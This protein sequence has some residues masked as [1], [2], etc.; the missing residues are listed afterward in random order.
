LNK[1]KT[2]KKEAK[3]RKDKNLIDPYTGEVEDP[4]EDAY[5][6][7]E[8]VPVDSGEREWE[9]FLL[10]E[11]TPLDKIAG[12]AEA[13]A[14]NERTNRY[15]DDENIEEVFTERQKLGSGGRQKLE[16][17]L[18]EHTAQNPKLTADDLDAAWEGSIVSGD[19]SVGEMAPT[20]GQDVVDNIGD[21]LGITY[22]DDEPLSGEEK[23]RERDRNRLEPNEIE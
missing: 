20:P 17:K 18:D 21:A 2:L 22:D 6:V 16:E 4:A 8:L 3:F 5:K 12:D 9:N 15:T 11:E 14:I 23:L 1:P 13:D 10:E 19:E 7:D